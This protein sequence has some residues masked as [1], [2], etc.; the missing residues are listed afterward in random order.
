MSST[1]DQIPETKE[2]LTARLLMA[3]ERLGSILAELQ[4]QAPSDLYMLLGHGD[5]AAKLAIELPKV[6]NV[7]QPYQGWQR[8]WELFG[9]FFLRSGRAFEAST[10]FLLLYDHLLQFQEITSIRVHKG[11]PLYWLATCHVALD[12]NVTA[13]R[14]LMLTLCEDA[15][16]D[17]G[18][19]DLQDSGS[20]FTLVWRLSF[21][22]CLGSEFKWN[23]GG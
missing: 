9:L 5:G 19:I 10:I 15:I 20:Y 12:N 23:R 11:V 2:A 3:D 6:L 22:T 4:V 7:A 14:Y 13:K 1:S 8:V 16:K 18:N 17:N 21:L